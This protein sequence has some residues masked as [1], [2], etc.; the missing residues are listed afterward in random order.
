MKNFIFYQKLLPACLLSLFLYSCVGEQGFDA[1]TQEDQEFKT[2]VQDPDL[3]E[4]YHNIFHHTRIR[5]DMERN[6]KTSKEGKLELEDIE[7]QIFEK[8]QLLAERYARFEDLN[9]QLTKQSEEYMHIFI[10][11]GVRPKSRY[12]NSEHSAC[13]GGCGFS[14]FMCIKL[15][16]DDED[17]L[18][19]R[20][21]LN[22]NGTYISCTYFCD[23]TYCV[24]Y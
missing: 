16:T 10:P 1:K 24:E 19:R 5:F 9:N 12:C 3:L 2:F 14:R 8:I 21:S 13:V 23:E 4:F 22:C 15:N 18:T 20:E 17:G 11:K 7:T 6:G